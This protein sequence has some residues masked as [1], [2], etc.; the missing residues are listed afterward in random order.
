MAKTP[1]KNKRKNPNPKYDPKEKFSWGEND[2]VFINKPKKQT[3]S[4]KEWFI[5][6]KKGL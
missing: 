3:M 4:L 5:R 6:L 2:I 1:V